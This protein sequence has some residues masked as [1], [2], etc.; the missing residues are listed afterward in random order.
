MGKLS[1]RDKV[2]SYTKTK[3]RWASREAERPVG[4]IAVIQAGGDDGAW[5]RVA[6]LKVVRSKINE[7]HPEICFNR[8]C[9]WNGCHVCEDSTKEFN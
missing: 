1:E 5:G 8:I 3:S 7:N 6:S 9:C 4:A 2:G